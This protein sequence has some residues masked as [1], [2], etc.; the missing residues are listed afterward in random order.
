MSLALF[1]RRQAVRRLCDHLPGAL[2]V[3]AGGVQLADGEADHVSAAHAGLGEIEA[4]VVIEGVQQSLVQTVERG[5]VIE[6]AAGDSG[7]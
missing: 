4:A 5:F 7:T 3:L 6:C 1:D 2:H